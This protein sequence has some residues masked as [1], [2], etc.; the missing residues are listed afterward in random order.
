MANLGVL[1]QIRIALA[2]APFDILVIFGADNVQYLTGVPL[3]FLYTHL[4]WRVAVV[5]SKDGNSG[6]ICPFELEASMDGSE[7]LDVIQAY[8]SGEGEEGI[9]RSLQKILATS[10]T[11]GSRVAVD[12]ARVPQSLWLRLGQEMGR[13]G[14]TSGDEWFA[15]VRMV[16]TEPE[17]QLLEDIAYRTDHA[18]LGASHHIMINLGHT[19]KFVSEDVR[20]H[21]LERFLDASGYN[22]ISNVASGTHSH[23]FWPLAPRF[24]LGQTKILQEGEFVRIEL[25][26]TLHGYWSSAARMI[27]MG[28]LTAYQK[29]SY[30]DLLTLRDSALS[31]LKP[32]TP[33]NQIWQ[34]IVDVAADARLDLVQELRLGHGVGVT[35]HEPP[36]VSPYDETELRPNMIV[37]L[38]PILRGPKGELVRSKDTILVTENGH[39]T[40]GWYKDWREPY[41]APYAL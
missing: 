27:S 35:A 11:Q 29:Q 18:I 25:Q 4:N 15:R 38:D 5:L 13:F 12:A 24:G 26:A 30:G 32:G 19:E 8:D 40:L 17:V 9:V 23:K 3:P 37:V 34:R 6:I 1:P 39:R 16:K 10:S 20:V 14:W 41:I 33:C 22:A 28:E 2:T 21:A 36:Y 31:L 7:E